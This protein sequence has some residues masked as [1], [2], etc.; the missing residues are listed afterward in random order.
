M[1]AAGMALVM[2]ALGAV[3]PLQAQRGVAVELRGGASAGNYAGAASNFELAPE[4]SFGAGASFGFTDALGV[5]AG[6]SRSTFR[7][8][9]GFCVERGVRFTSQGMEAG[10]QLQLP[11]IA[12]PWLRAGVVRHAL[13]YDAQPLDGAA[14]D[15]EE[16]SGTG[17]SAG[18]GLEVRLG[19]RLSL[20]P[21]VRYLRYGGGDDGAVAV[22]VG[23]V[24]V[25]IR[26]GA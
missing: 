14:S 10:V 6:Y 22:V 1:K 25:K 16:T 5:Y 3:A 17:F 23:D 12:A 7:C 20:T 24:G 8:E 13:A 4:P 19:R 2:V 18:G 26:F 11:V 15:G 21:G 9:S